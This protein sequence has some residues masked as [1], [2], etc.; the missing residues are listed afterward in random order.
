MID[1]VFI[2]FA[3]NTYTHI[4]HQLVFSMTILTYCSLKLDIL[5][6]KHD[7]VYRMKILAFGKYSFFSE[8][9]LYQTRYNSL[10]N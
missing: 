1:K 9:L 6:V 2:F 10:I 8:S 7:H 3:C 5:T 4:L